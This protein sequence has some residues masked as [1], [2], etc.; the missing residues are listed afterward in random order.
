MLEYVITYKINIVGRLTDLSISKLLKIMGSICVILCIAVVVGLYNINVYIGNERAAEDR[1]DEIRKLTTEFISATN[2]KT[3]TVVNYIMRGYDEKY[4]EYMKEVNENKTQEKILSQFKDLNISEEN[5]KYLQQAK[6][7][8]EQLTEIEI[9]A[10]E[11]Y[12]EGKTSLANYLISSESYETRKDAMER[13]LNFFQNKIYEEAEL[14][15]SEMMVRT[16]TLYHYIY[17]AIIVLIIFILL[18]IIILGRKISRLVDISE[19]MTELSN[20]EGDLTS[21]IAIKSKDEIGKIAS[22]FNKMISNLRNLM[23]E[24]NKTTDV[25]VSEAEK[26]ENTMV[27]ISANMQGINNSVYEITAGAEELSATTQEVNAY[28]EE[29]ESAAQQLESKAE[30]AKNSADEIKKRAAEIKNKSIEA[31]EKSNKIYKEKYEN[32]MSALDE[33]RVVEEVK[34]MADSIGNIASQT[35]LLALNAAIEA[36]RVGEAGKGFAVVADEVRN[37]AEQSSH[38]VDNIYN[39]VDKVSS[40]FG[41]LS[42]A[43]QEILD[44]MSNEMKPSY[45]LLLSTGEQYNNDAD[46]VIGMSNDIL[47]AVKTMRDSIE[48]V[49]GSLQNV[50]TIAQQS[51]AGTEEI[52]ATVSEAAEKVERVAESVQEQAKLSLEL[53]ELISKFKI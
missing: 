8:S 34:V 52:S 43:A 17:I 19:K 15:T 2:Y 5:M 25:V 24:V 13:Y 21:Q 18:T 28:T 10:M 20:N 37:L 27:Q 14:Y 36:A 46:F 53:K 48:Q 42:M 26:L 11:A 22:A 23:I 44:F 16:D 40:A 45:E 9:E 31:I 38:A 6:T 4:D 47:N 50:S 49:S 7:L 30:E 41:K 1:E 39:M 29:I 51:A 32:I 33:G 3:Q 12:R 35:N